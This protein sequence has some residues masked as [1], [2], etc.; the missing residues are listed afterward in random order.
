[1]NVLLAAEDAAGVQTLRRLQTARHRLV[2]VLASPERAKAPGSVWNVA[3]TLGHSCWPADLVRTP[4]LARRIRDERIDVLINVHSLVLIHAEVLAAPP[5]GCFN[6]HPGPLPRYAGLNSVC[7]AIYHGETTHGVT[8]HRMTPDV[9]AGDIA[10]QAEVPIEAH[11]TGLTLASRC[12]KAGVPLVLELLDTLADR[13]HDLPRR[14]QDRTRRTFFAARPP[15]S[16]RLSWHAPARQIVSFV[17]AADFVPFQ[18]PWGHPR[19]FSGDLEVG[20]A[21][22]RET[23][24]QCAAAPGTVRKSGNGHVDVAARD[25]WVAVQLIQ[26]GGRYC[27][28]DEVLAP[29]VILN[30][31]PGS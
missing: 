8:L 17:R 9:D 14:D 28:P 25:Q 12:V 20:I 31:E 5:L 22:A 16:G 27:A 24:E 4:D 3:K 7:W 26:T 23:G 2:A 19:S 29:G 6:L 15:N 30:G 21:K 10:Y 13:P 1:M 18:S 11:D